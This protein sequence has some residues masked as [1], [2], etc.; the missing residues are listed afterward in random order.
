MKWNMQRQP[1]PGYR[2]HFCI[3]AARLTEDARTVSG[4]IR[5]K[6]KDCGVKPG[7]EEHTGVCLLHAQPP[8]LPTAAFFDF[9]GL[10]GNRMVKEDI[11]TTKR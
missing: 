3:F 11:Q 1:A 10:P 2:I 4:I 8:G 7:E 6:K 5:N 9:P